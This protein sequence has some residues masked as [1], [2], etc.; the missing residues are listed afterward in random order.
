[1]FIPEKCL[2]LSK[3]SELC[4]LL[5]AY[6]HIPIPGSVIALKT[7]SITAMVPGK[8]GSLTATEWEEQIWSSQKSA[9]PTE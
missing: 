9:I 6:S 2:N 1:M 3:N 7:K 4:I 8:A 5:T